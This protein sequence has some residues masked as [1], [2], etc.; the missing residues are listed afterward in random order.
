VTHG[1]TLLL[2]TSVSMPNLIDVGQTIRAYEMDPNNK[3]LDPSDLALVTQSHRNRRGSI[4]YA[5]LP[6]IV[7]HSRMPMRDKKSCEH[8]SE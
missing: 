2:S 5:R 6:N 4:G 7:T 1:S 3:S 8:I